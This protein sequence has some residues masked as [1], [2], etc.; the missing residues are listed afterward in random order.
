LVD[1]RAGERIVTPFGRT[2]DVGLQVEVL[3]RLV[4]G[5]RV[6]LVLREQVTRGDE[7]LDIRRTNIYRVLDGR[8]TEID[9]YEA[10]QYEV[11]AFFA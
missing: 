6:V 3:D 1:G 9:V 10:D 5:E 4:S 7:H 11:D 2:E 8:I